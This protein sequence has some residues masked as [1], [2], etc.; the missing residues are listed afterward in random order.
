MLVKSYLLDHPELN[1][2]LADYIQH[3]LTLKPADI[4][5]FTINHFKNFAPHFF[6]KNDYYETNYVEEE[7]MFTI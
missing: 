3:I 7:E 4:L 6:P 1:N 5:E 2:V